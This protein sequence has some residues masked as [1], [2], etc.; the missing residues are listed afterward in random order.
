MKYKLWFSRR[1]TANRT[2]NAKLRKKNEELERKVD[3]LERDFNSNGA[4]LDEISLENESL[5]EQ[6]K[7][8]EV[9]NRILQL[10]VDKLAEVVARDRVRVHA[11]TAQLKQNHMLDEVSDVA[12][13]S[14]LGT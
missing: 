4:E 14:K 13:D 11:E 7:A 6:I 5:R 12:V 2:A 9:D 10:E 3:S 8:L 1:R